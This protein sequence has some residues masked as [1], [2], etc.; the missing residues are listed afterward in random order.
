MSRLWLCASFAALYADQTERDFAA[1]R[2]AAKSKRIK[3]VEEVR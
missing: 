2:K 1:L 3:V